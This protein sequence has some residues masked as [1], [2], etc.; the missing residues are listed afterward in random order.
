MMC[1]SCQTRMRY[2]YGELSSYHCDT[3]HKT[4]FVEDLPDGHPDKTFAH[5][6]EQK[7][8]KGIENG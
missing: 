7:R 8:L 6:E 2:V 1:K 4:V 5:L 3:C